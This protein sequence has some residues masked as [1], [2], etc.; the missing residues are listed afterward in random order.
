M[1]ARQSRSS[2]SV[3]RGILRNTQRK[4]SADENVRILRDG[5]TGRVKTSVCWDKSALSCG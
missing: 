2:E 1:R 3:V 4:S 5:A